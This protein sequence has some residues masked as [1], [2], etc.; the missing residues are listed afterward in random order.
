MIFGLVTVVS[1]SWICLVCLEPVGSY[2]IFGN[3]S[4]CLHFLF[5]KSCLEISLLPLLH[6]TPW[7]RYPP[8]CGGWKYWV[9]PAAKDYHDNTCLPLVII[10]LN[11]MS[12]LLCYSPYASASLC[13]F[14]AKKGEKVFASVAWLHL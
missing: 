4:H 11:V 5:I 7:K 14:R 9:S 1:G 10:C 6:L 13:C 3:T 2:T 12:C 8:P